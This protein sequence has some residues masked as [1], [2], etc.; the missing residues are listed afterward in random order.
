MAHRFPAV[1]GAPVHLGLPEGI[2]VTDLSKPDLGEPTEV[3]ADELPV[4]WV[5]G[6]T[7]QA[8]VAWPKPP[9]CITHFL[10][11]MVITD[12]RNAE[13]AAL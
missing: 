8:V 7:P 4:F 5:C 10:G 13:L 1:H 3:R 11:S 9:F 12:R 6:V 2:G